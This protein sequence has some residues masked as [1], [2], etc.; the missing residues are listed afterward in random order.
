M[1]SELKYPEWQEPLLEAVT[2]RRGLPIIESVILDRLRFSDGG[3]EE[4]EALL[5][6]LAVIRVIKRRS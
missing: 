3:K 5:D 1:A 2:N 6:A 4:R